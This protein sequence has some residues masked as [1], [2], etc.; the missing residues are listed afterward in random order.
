LSRKITD[1]TTSWQRYRARHLPYSTKKCS[2]CSG[3]FNPHGPQQRCDSCRTFNCPQCGENFMTNVRGRKFCS[4][5][6]LA[7][8]HIETLHAH[9]GVKP[10][11]YHLRHR[12]KHGNAMDR[13]WR[14]AIF[15]RDKYTC[16]R[17]KVKGG[18]LQAHHIKP[19]KDYPSLRYVLS[20]GLTLCVPC[21]KRTKTYGWQ[22]YHKN[23]KKIAAKRLAQEVMQ[24]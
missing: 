16:R 24:F 3:Q 1:G 13:E 18:R 17:C 10:R 2:E 15:Q 5:K 11:T 8:A 6:C 9:R 7:L 22:K 4:R 19:Y 21:H 23:R 20:N 12:D 14:T